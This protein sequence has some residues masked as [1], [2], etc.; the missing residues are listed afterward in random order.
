V[1]TPVT[2]ATAY[3]CPMVRMPVSCA[4][5][6]DASTAARIRS[7]TMSTERNRMR[8]TH[9]PAGSPTTRNAAV[10]TATSAPTSN[11]DACSTKIATSGSARS[12]IIV[13]NWLIVSPIHSRRKAR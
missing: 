4:S 3:S 10:W 9:A 2:S 5:G 6:I 12:L 11:V 13:P 1:L 7:F 8:S